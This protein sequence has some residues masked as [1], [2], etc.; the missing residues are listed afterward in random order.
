MAA[1]GLRSWSTGLL[2]SKVGAE[3]KGDKGGRGRNIR[4]GS[5]EEDIFPSGAEGQSSPSAAILKTSYF[6]QS[7]L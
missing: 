5:E 6:Y 7:K 4:G 3:R 2:P 1:L